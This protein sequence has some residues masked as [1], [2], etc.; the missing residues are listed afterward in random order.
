MNGNTQRFSSLINRPLVFAILS[1]L[2]ALGWRRS[3]ESAPTVNSIGVRMIPVPAGSFL[4]GGETT[5]I[6]RLK[7]WAPHERG[8]LP[9]GD[10]DERPVHRVT[11]S[12]PF[13]IS[14]TEITAAQYARFR[15]YFLDTG[16]YS[17]YVSGVSW[18]DAEEFCRWLSRKEGRNYRLPTE[19]EWEY[20]CRAGPSRYSACH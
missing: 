10:W 18:L 4:M 11:M 9:E 14:E 15:P 7:G 13:L 16:R 20:A 17:P 12:Q 8:D 3:E 19:A 2:V 1:A 5:D 6:G